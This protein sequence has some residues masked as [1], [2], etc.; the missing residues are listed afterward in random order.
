MKQTFYFI[1][2][3]CLATFSA[4]AQPYGNE[5]IDYSKT[6]HRIEITGPGTS[7]N[8]V[9][10]TS[11]TGQYGITRIDRSTLQTYNL[12]GLTGDGFKIFNKGQEIPIYVSTTGNFGPSDYIEFFWE[13]NDGELDANLYADPDWQPNIGRSLFTDRARYYLVWDD[14]TPGKRF[15]NVANN[16][17]NTLTKETYFMRTNRVSYA[18][19]ASSGTTLDVAEAEQESAEFTE[20]EGILSDKIAP[21]RPFNK[22]L[23]V[24]NFYNGAGAPRPIFETSVAGASRGDGHHMRISFNGNPFINITYDD[25]EVKD[26]STPLSF[27]T[28]TTPLTDITYESVGDNLS[29]DQQFVAYSQLTYP[30]VFDFD[31]Q[32]FFKFTLT[33]N[34]A[35]YVEIDNFNGG[36][37]PVIYDLTNNIRILPSFNG[38]LYQ[39]E[40]PAGNDP[41]LGE[42]ELIIFNTQNTNCIGALGDYSCFDCGLV[43]LGCFSFTSQMEAVNFT[44]YSDPANQGDYVIITNQLLRQGGTDYIQAYA[45]YRASAQGRGFTPVVVNIDELYDQFAWGIQTHP[46][47]IRHF[48]NFMVNEWASKPE[49]L[50]L[51]GKSISYDAILLSENRLA[52]VLVPTY[53]ASPSDNILTAP[54]AGTLFP[55]IPIGRIPAISPDE[56][57][58]YLQKLIEYESPKPC[59]VDERAWVRD[60]AHVSV[61]ADPLET[62]EILGYLSNYGDIVVQ[63]SYS[64]NLVATLSALKGSGNI[65]TLKSYME[66]GL[67]LLTFFGHSIG[68]NWDIGGI[69]GGDP[70]YFNNTGKYPFV[71]SASCFVGNIHKDSNNTM[72]EQYIV[73]AD[74]GAIG[75]LAT[76]SFGMPLALNEFCLDFYD[77]F[78]ISNYGQPM[79]LSIFNSINNMPF[80]QVTPNGEFYN[81]YL[82]TAE[83]FT[84]VGD[85]AVIL[86]G[87]TRPEYYV[88]GTVDVFDAATNTQ[89]TGSPII[90]PD[91]QVYFEV[92]VSN[93]GLA[94]ANS[95]IDIT[96]SQ[97][98]P[99]GT[100]VVVG[101]SN[102]GAPSGTSTFTIPVTVNNSDL[103]VPNTFTVTVSSN[104]FAEDCTDNNSASVQLQK[105][106]V[107]CASLPQPVI[108]VPQSNLC[109]YN[110][111]INLTA[112]PP[113]GAFSGSG[114]AGATFNAAQAGAGTH[115]INYNYTDAATGC[116]LFASTQITVTVPPL[117]VINVNNRICLNESVTISLSEVDQSADYLWDFGDATVTSLGNEQYELTWTVGGPKEILLSTSKN[118]CDSDSRTSFIQVDTPLDRP[119]ISCGNTT[120]S[121]V[122]FEW[123]PVSRADSYELELNGTII[124]L[125]N[126]QTRYILN[127]LDQGTVFTARIRAVNDDS[128]GGSEF[129]FPQECASISCPSKSLEITNLASTYCETDPVV[130]LEANEPG[131]RFF[132]EGGGPVTRNIT[133]FDPSTSGGTY[134]LTYVIEEGVCVYNSPTYEITV[135]SNPEVNI[136][137]NDS[138]CVGEDTELSVTSDHSSLQ[139]LWSNGEVTKNITVNTED[140]YSVT[141]TD[142]NGCSSSTSINVSQNNILEP[143]IDAGGFSAICNGQEITLNVEGD[144]TD[145][146]WTGNA[147]NSSSLNITNPGTYGVTVTNSA[148]CRS[149]NSIVIGVGSIDAPTVSASG[150]N[151]GEDVAICVGT[152]LVISVPDEYSTYLWSNG[153]TTPNITVNTPDTY[154][155]TV[156]N[157]QGCLSSSAI[158]VG[159]N[160]IEAPS[161][162][163]SNNLTAICE[164]QAATLSVPADFAT[165]VWSTGGTGN[166]IDV[167]SPGNYT[168]TVTSADGCRAFNNFTLDATTIEA[169]TLLVDEV[170]STGSVTRCEG[171][172]LVL[173]ISD[174]FA[175]YAWSDGTEV[176]S[177]ESSITV[178][179]A[180]TYSVAVTTPE[181]CASNTETVSVSFNQIATPSIAA[182]ETGICASGGTVTLTANDGFETYAWSTGDTGT[183]I[184]VTEAGTYSLAVTQNGCSNETSSTIVVYEDALG[185]LDINASVAEI[186]VGEAVELTGVGLDGAVSF[187]WR[188]EGLS[189]TSTETVVATPTGEATYTLTATDENGCG[190]TDSIVIALNQ[191]CELPNAITPRQVDG[192]NDSWIIPQAYTNSNVHV[193]IFNRWGQKVWETTSYNNANGWTGTNDGGVELAH[194]TYYYIIELN[195]GSTDPIHGPITVLE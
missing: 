21:G 141:I 132:L 144:Y 165:Y 157:T 179:T 36:S 78:T 90:I 147:S 34:D 183:S 95:T 127:D 174:A 26:F 66:N 31:N 168:V 115:I 60:V 54:N 47:S 70:T 58:N 65:N 176:I 143:V 154:S 129:S 51:I 146:I 155:V 15:N 185:S 55:Q 102:F 108:S 177:T 113:G 10:T 184:E 100:S 35:A 117:P 45:D 137:G 112:T 37:L 187:D 39:L 114:V 93:M 3:L 126:D 142:D 71:I 131:G 23:V 145:F 81:A 111:T 151:P 69:G 107:N 87:F 52:N 89:L 50:L 4:Q 29:N 139:Y 94:V 128:C 13:E 30:S 19:N 134:R 25:F 172:S 64:G 6:Y 192:S 148:G 160:S 140:T 57:N 189:S 27:S 17:S 170:N 161:I 190:K 5:W 106:E 123:S 74:H 173:T 97:Q 153:S 163:E 33:H 186:C 162:T 22:K 76:V 178:S 122:S 158:T 195:D 135:Y 40:L 1:L 104:D 20:G 118:G 166:S 91:D 152:D 169:P 56:V 82:L 67:G 101:T 138:F 110:E 43:P 85:P 53:G 182:S 68:D 48:S 72:A 62:D 124:P 88:N 42:R 14:S 7:D 180:G 2:L 83:Q 8:I 103:L 105:Q 92:T 136:L 59:R 120:L 84:L 75:F 80:D 150:F 18:N 63:P 98:L 79:G 9:P 99:D 86:G 73:T 133:E 96:V 119:V 181:G 61:G 38:F 11:F 77:Q 167:T 175:T 28:L 32:H 12:A 188:G 130:I 156:T 44:D 193:Q 125:G 194:G 171:E 24:K 16:I 46:L 121:S 116:Q 109:L 164:G 159:V 149:S 49:Y 191:V 41:S